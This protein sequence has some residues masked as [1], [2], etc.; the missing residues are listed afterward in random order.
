VVQGVV[1][2]KNVSDK[3]FMPLPLVFEFPGGQA[4]RGTVSAAGPETPF[5]IKLPSAP[6]KVT[7]D[8]DN[9]ILSEKTATSSGK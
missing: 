4:A 7:L 1:S 6:S 5:T 9:W 3:W 2:Q 8:P